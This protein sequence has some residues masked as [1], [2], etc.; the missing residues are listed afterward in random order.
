MD[1]RTVSI[2]PLPAPNHKKT[3]VFTDSHK[4]EPPNSMVPKV[5]ETT[6]PIKVLRAVRTEVSVEAGQ[7]QA[8]VLPPCA[9]PFVYTPRGK[10]P[11]QGP[12]CPFC[13]LFRGPCRGCT[14]RPGVLPPSAAVV[15]PP[16][17]VMPKAKRL[18]ATYRPRDSTQG[19]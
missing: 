12:R 17:L 14:V 19:P 4:M 13:W 5:V 11:H 1:G 18:R 10:D 2:P 15:P 9:S 6:Q 7:G 8:A 3:L 16:P